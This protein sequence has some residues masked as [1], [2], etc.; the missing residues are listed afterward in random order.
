[1]RG[2]ARSSLL[3]LVDAASAFA[4]SCRSDL[5]LVTADTIWPVGFQRLLAQS[6]SDARHCPRAA[7]GY[8]NAYACTVF[9]AHPLSQLN[10]FAYGEQPTHAYRNL[11]VCAHSDGYQ[12]SRRP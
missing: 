5:V 7:N 1:M 6:H 3:C 10:G 4:G 2:R 9:Y 12:D 11:Y 8:G